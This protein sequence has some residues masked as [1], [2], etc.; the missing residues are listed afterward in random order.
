LTGAAPEA[1]VVASQTADEAAASVSALAATLKAIRKARPDGEGFIHAK[2]RGIVPL[3]IGPSVLDRSIKLLA[4]IF[5]LA[6]TQGYETKATDD[7]LQLAVDGEMVAFALEAPADRSL[8]QPTPSELREQARYAGWGMTRAPWPKYDHFP[9]ERLSIVL[10][11]NAHSGLRRTF[12][13][14]QTKR[15]EQMLPSVLEA[16]AEHAAFAKECRR[17]QEESARRYQEAERLRR[18]DESFAAREKRRIEFANAVHEVLAERKKWAEVLAH[19]ETAVDPE[20]PSTEIIEWLRRRIRQL[21]ALIS[22]A[23]LDFSARS[24]KV[25][26]AEGKVISEEDRYTYYP[27]VSLQYWSIDHAAGQ[28]RAQS[29]LQWIK[30]NGVEGPGTCDEPPS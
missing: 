14:R 25:S 5:T 8:H 27:P 7:G 16:F 9:S 15:L 29:A 20:C 11:A 10:Q 1:L 4:Q 26:F 17:E 19:M 28:A 30:E 18:L 13:D 23:F 24:V 2:G 3:K 22:P 21:D 12:S 6:K